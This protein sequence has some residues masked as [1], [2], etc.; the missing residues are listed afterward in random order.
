MNVAITVRD[1]PSSVRDE[2]A[3]R[4]ARAGRSMQEYVKAILVDQVS[5]PPAEDWLA[6]TRQ[7][8]NRVESHVSTSVILDARDA[9]R[10]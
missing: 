8:V 2:L 9:D 3:A 7:R 6:N 10:R 4:A 1:I 5:F